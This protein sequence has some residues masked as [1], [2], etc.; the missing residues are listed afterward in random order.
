MPI[1]DY[2]SSHAARG[3][4]A[5]YNQTYQSGYYAALWEKVER[6]IVEEL[7]RS[8]G[9]PDRTC[10]DFAC[11]TG[12]ITNVAAGFFG[13][14]V[15]VDVSDSMIACAIPIRNAKLLLQ[16]ITKNSLRDTFDVATAFRFFLNAED[17]LRREALLTIRNHL[18]DR[19]RIICNIHVNASSPAGLASR[20]VNRVLRQT[21]HNTLSVDRMEE[22]LADAGFVVENVIAYGFLPR[23]GRFAPSLC[24]ILIEPAEKFCKALGVPSRFAQHFIIVATKRPGNCSF[25]PKVSSIRGVPPHRPLRAKEFPP[26]RHIG[27]FLKLD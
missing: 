12:R 24:E 5:R 23:P 26:A 13:K 25:L 10:L 6:P 17:K 4:G 15:G 16:D 9:G 8:V 19:G 3:Y 1:S 14:V 21:S 20:L 11:G 18:A 7:F 2:R 27:T 22:L